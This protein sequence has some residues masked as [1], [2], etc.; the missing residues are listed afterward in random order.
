MLSVL[1]AHTTRD[2]ENATSKVLKLVYVC[3]GKNVI[4]NAVL[5]IYIV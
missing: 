3:N 5:Y 2:F 1:T 4:E